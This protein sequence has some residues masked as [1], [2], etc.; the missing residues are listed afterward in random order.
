MI[1]K[2]FS[3]LGD[4]TATLF[5]FCIVGIILAIELPVKFLVVKPTRALC[6][7]GYTSLRKAINKPKA[8][9]MARYTPAI[10]KDAPNLAPAKEFRF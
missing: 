9:P 8:Q 5:A 4:S 10:F 7:K 2:L 1:K 3:F 6:K